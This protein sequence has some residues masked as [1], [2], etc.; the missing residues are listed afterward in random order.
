MKGVTRASV[1]VI[2]TSSSIQLVTQSGGCVLWRQGLRREFSF[3]RF[4][5]AFGEH[6]PRSPQL[7]QA[8]T[9]EVRFLLSFE[10]A[11]RIPWAVGNSLYC[12]ALRIS[13]VL[14]T[15]S[16]ER[17]FRICFL[18]LFGAIG[19]L[20]FKGNTACFPRFRSSISILSR[21]ARGVS[22][23]CFQ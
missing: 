8:Q 14:G 22:L 3:F 13:M 1:R 12:Y 9:K 7:L 20:G 2:V 15:D 18:S 5:L 19:Q 11:C 21:S 17:S 23:C 4:S 10:S 6:R 16:Q